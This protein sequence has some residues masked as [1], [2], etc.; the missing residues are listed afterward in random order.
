MANDTKIVIDSVVDNLNSVQEI[1]KYVSK[2][3][4]QSWSVMAFPN[5]G[6]QNHPDAYATLT[7]DHVWMTITRSFYI[8]K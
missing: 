6:N 3:T 5:F 2:Y 8:D 1:S 4:N 7:A